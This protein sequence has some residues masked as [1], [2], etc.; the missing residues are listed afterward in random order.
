MP[1]IGTECVQA[2]YQPQS[3]EPR[4]VPIIQ[5]TTFKYDT[6]E[7]MGK[8]FDLEEEGYFYT[9][10]QN[11]TND[12]VAAKIAALE[13]G[14]AAMLTSSGQA[15]NFYAVFNIAGAGDHVVS[16]SAIYGGT[17][18]LFA[19]T[20]AR[21]GIET[22]FVTPDCTDEELEA[23]FK[24]NTKAVFGETIANPA[25]AVLD[26]ERFAKAAHAHG[27]P[28]II[29][30]TFPTPINCRPI[31]WGADI[32]THSTTTY[33]D[34]HGAAVGGAIVD[35]GNFDWDAHADKFPGLTTPDETY[36][37]VTYTERFGL[38]G[39][40]ITKATAQLMRDFGSIQ[41]PQNAFLLNFGLEDLHLRMKRHCENG[42]AVAEFLH[43]HPKVSWVRY[44]G[45]PDDEYYEVAQKY[46]PNGS[47]G[48]VS[49]GVKGGRSAAEQ[50][51]SHLKLAQIATHVADARTCVLHPANATHRQM[52]DEELEAA[53]ISA[54]LIRFSCGIE[55]TQDLIND[56][57]Q[58]LDAV[59]EVA[60]A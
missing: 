57:A 54:D 1:G 18:N 12:A 46:L 48:V 14:T 11:P 8:L 15:A 35:S 17:Y 2:G 13:G 42:Q 59:S 19:H 25:L 37:G 50:F 23:A 38:G 24:P 9:R 52:N 53:G 7:H 26:I 55:D 33:M 60:G 30:N 56:I 5:S 49:F 29:D 21:M 44:C 51:M 28:L 6:S 47:C 58:A 31:E 40:F 32:V 41:S 10:L 45:L 36:H 27:V 16:S 34:G 22:T 43:D 39:A 20:M 3:G 4:Q